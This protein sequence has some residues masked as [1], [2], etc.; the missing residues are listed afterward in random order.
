MSIPTTL[1]YTNGFNSAVEVD[2]DLPSDKARF[3]RDSA[4][5]AGW[6]FL[7]H[8]ADYY[9]A[10]QMDKSLN[11]LI[12]KARTVDER[13]V[14]MG[15]SMGGLLSL[16]ALGELD[17][18]EARAV[19][20]NPVLVPDETLLQESLGHEVTNYVT[21]KTHLVEVSAHKRLNEWLDRVPDIMT[22]LGEAVEVHLDLGDEVLVSQATAEFCIPWCD[23]H[24]YP[25]GSHRFEHWEESWRHIVSI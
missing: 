2:G 4:R 9:S 17:R 8:N 11:R 14:L 5:R 21:G 22:R 24:E 7:A 15:C 12:E 20:I 16:L 6:R 1:L 3:Y 13:P 18:P 10:D 19:L 25:G 23:V